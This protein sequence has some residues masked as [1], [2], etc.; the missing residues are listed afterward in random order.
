MSTQS[1]ELKELAKTLDASQADKTLSSDRRDREI[2]KV[3]NRHFGPVLLH[4]LSAH[5][6]EQFKRERL[7]G[8]WKAHGQISAAKPVRPATV[9]RELDTSSRRAT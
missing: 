8:R 7:S 4:E 6:I 5:R 9:N 1:R 2:V 3:L